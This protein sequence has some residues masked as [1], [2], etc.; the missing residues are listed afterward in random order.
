M[1]DSDL[2]IKS[3]LFK[4]V[5]PVPNTVPQWPALITVAATCPGPGHSHPPLHSLQTTVSGRSHG[6]SH[7]PLQTTISGHSHPPLQTTFNG[8]SHGHSHPPLQTTFSG[9]SHPPLKT[10]FSGPGLNYPLP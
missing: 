6:H 1:R 9:H 7:P 8:R 3:N 10:T 5:I 4:Q 2:I